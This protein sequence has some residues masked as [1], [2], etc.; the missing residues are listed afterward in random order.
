MMMKIRIFQAVVVTRLLYGLSSAWLSVAEV[1]RLN[2]FQAWCLRKVA[3]IKRS[4]VSR[5]SNATV[6]QKNSQKQ[7]GEQLLKQQVLL[8]GKVARAQA[9]DM[10]RDLAFVPGTQQPTTD[11]YVRRVG[12]PRNEWAVMLRREAFKMSPQAE[13]IIH[14]RRLWQ[15]VV[16]QYFE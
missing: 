7:L 10:L 16:E 2:G 11:Q 14:D 9:G 12:R 8:Y 6:L 4:F 1:R 5:V 13:T 15:R 3:G